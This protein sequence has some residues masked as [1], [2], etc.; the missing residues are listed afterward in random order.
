MLIILSLSWLFVYLYLHLFVEWH[1]GRGGKLTLQDIDNISERSNGLVRLNTLKH[2]LV[3]DGSEMAL[4][5]RESHG[6]VP[7]EIYGK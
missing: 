2:Y 6:D 4:M 3:Q 1:H 5:Y 7:D